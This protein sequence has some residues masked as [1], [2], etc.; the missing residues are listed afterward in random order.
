MAFFV[1]NQFYNL[2]DEVE[3]RFRLLIRKQVITGIDEIKF[4]AWLSNFT[5]TEDRYLAARLMDGLIFRSNSMVFSSIDHLLQ[6]I[7]PKELKG[8]SLFPYQNIEE[9]LQSL[10]DGDPLPT[11]LP[12]N[13]F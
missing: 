10:I 11:R 4:D 2:Y 7:L 6:S 1:P 8:H 9:F 12:L 3:Q 5:S 13:F